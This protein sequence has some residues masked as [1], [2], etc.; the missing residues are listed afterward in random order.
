M[1]VPVKVTVN[2]K[3]V[4]T[5]AMLDGGATATVVKESLTEK[6]KTEY[7]QKDSTLVTVTGRTKAKR[8]FASFTISN[9]T[10]DTTL[11]I[12]NAVV[13]DNLTTE[14]DIPPT[15]EE[16]KGEWYLNGVSF[17]ELPEKS[18]DLLI[19]IEYAWCWLGGEMRRSTT[20]KPMAIK[21]RFGWA[22]AGGKLNESCTIPSCYKVAVEYD[23]DSIKE[24]VKKLFKREFPDIL[25]NKVHDSIDDKR[26]M[27][28]ME[29]T[30]YFD[31]EIGHYKVG[32]P[33]KTSREEVA[34][35]MN[36]INSSKT[37]L[38]RITKQI[39]KIK[40]DKVYFP[41]GEYFGYVKNQMKGIFDDG[42]VERLKENDIKEGIPTWVMPLNVV[43]QPHKPTK[44][45]CCHDGKAATGGVSLNDELLAG[46]DL[47]NS[48]LGILFKFR[49]N[50]VAVSADIK[51]FFHQVYVDDDDKH[52]FRFW[53]FADEA[54]TIPCLCELKVHVFG[55]KSS[56]TIC[57]F[58]LRHHGKVMRQEISVETFKAIMESFYVDDHLASYVS[59][60]EARRVRI[61]L[62][63]TLLKGGF[64]LLKWKA[65]HKGVVE[66]ENEDEEDEIFIEEEDDMDQ[67]DKI[68]GVKY[69]FKKDHFF[70]YVKPEKI[71]MLVDTRR[72]LLKVVASCYDPLGIISPFMLIGKLIFQDA[73]K[74]A[75]S[76]GWDDE[77]PEE[78][79][80]RMAKWQSQ[81][82]EMS[83]FKIDRWLKSEETLDAKPELHL[84]SDAS[85]KAYGFVA[86]RRVQ[87]DE[88]VEVKFLFSKAR[89]IPKDQAKTRLHNSIPK[90]ELQAATSAAEFVNKFLQECGEE[91]GEI[92]MHT[93][94]ECVR[95]QIYNTDKRFESYVANRL[96][97]IL[98]NTL[99]E[100]WNYV[101]TKNNPADYCSR[102]LNPNEK[103]KWEIFL[104]GP[105]FLWE[106]REQWC[107]EDPPNT[108]DDMEIGAVEVV[109][110]EP[111]TLEPLVIKCARSENG[112]QQ[113]VEAVA[114]MEKCFKALKKETKNGENTEVETEVTAEERERAEVLINKGLQRLHFPKEWK[115]VKNKKISEPNQRLELTD[116]NSKL[117][118]LNVFMD[119]D[120][121]LRAGSRLIKSETLEY[122]TKCP[123]ILPRDDKIVEDLVRHTHERMSHGGTVLTRSILREKYHIIND[124]ICV[125]KVVAKCVK[126][127]IQRG[128]PIDQK[129][130]PLP[131]DRLE[132]GE[133]FSVSGVDCFGPYIVKHR[134]RSTAKR[135]VVIFTCL[136]TRAIHLE[137]VETMST[138]SFLMALI[139][140]T[141]RRPGVRKL[142]SDCGTNFVGA[143]A[144]L[145]RAVESW[146]NTAIAGARVTCLEWIFLPPMAHHRAGVWERMIKSVKKHLN[147]VLGKQPLEL[148][149]LVTMLAQVEAILNFRPITQVS[150]DPN[151]MEALSPAG[152]LYPGVKLTTSAA[153]LP[154][155]PPGGES[156]RYSF[157]KARAL[158]D[159]FWKRWVQEYVVTL[160]N[161]Q[162]WL[163]TKGDLVE[164][165]LVLMVDEVKSRDQ[166]KLA[167]VISVTGDESHKRTIEVK[168]ANGKTFKRDVSKVVPLEID[169]E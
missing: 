100:W 9:L 92:F 22:L 91:Y 49:L 160:R 62:T 94:S 46:A 35:R 23:D 26:A 110:E 99:A 10:G 125:K 105:K 113:R 8:N 73:M 47:L 156:L 138:P 142:Y 166:W 164:G 104:T 151:D 129:M 167:R 107:L 18:V 133:A 146:N 72:K 122:D 155:A 68:L 85:S 43:Y 12:K 6:L 27:E 148:D 83:Q 150:D 16:I 135:W 97:R 95:R 41:P 66:E 145:K 81:I 161:R 89:V 140:F 17:V 5:Y 168:T 42:H 61:E 71:N 50:K 14:S 86:Y 124:G 37:S 158:V 15:N 34:S 28:R 134:A 64:E 136:K 153:I 141:S 102:G 11:E 96:S 56:P 149:V 19:P 169:T 93:D 154:P 112:W 13:V 120:G 52:V 117:R 21:T 44:P 126:C 32:L 103:E 144:E 33:W 162:K 165:Q 51:G 106:K 1:I 53:W 78:L 69:S 131:V 137:M 75:N 55:A 101:S 30:I 24:D 45:R 88:K 4:E 132:V 139:R 130:A 74:E 38:S 108:L 147:S 70:F 159:A 77:L 57:T 29:E 152:I 82:A 118:K 54:C 20:D 157:Q 25:E 121:L 40:E 79:K 128:K 98:A 65:T 3:T 163:G 119:K 59:V 2:H 67:A 116:K 76:W 60:P 109:P 84:F 123:I 87:K 63:E 31:K 80:T 143:E 58:A 111:P 114:T 115:K 36:K 90:Y 7:E 127:Q 48:L 39:K